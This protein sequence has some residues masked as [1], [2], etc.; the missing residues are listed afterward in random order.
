MHIFLWGYSGSRNNLILVE[1]NLSERSQTDTIWGKLASDW[2]PHLDLSSS[3]L[4]KPALVRTVS[5]FTCA[6]FYWRWESCPK[7]FYKL[8][9]SSILFSCKHEWSKLTK[10]YLCE[11]CPSFPGPQHLML[12]GLMSSLQPLVSAKGLSLP[13]L[14]L[15][16]TLVN[17]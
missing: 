12:V 14:L 6:A 15:K 10:S 13:S 5:G 9:C 11:A 17:W 4:W 16:T 2:W 1:L 8:S 3:T 7:I